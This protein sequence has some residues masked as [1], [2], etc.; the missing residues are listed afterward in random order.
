MVSV[1]C[2]RC[3]FRIIINSEQAIYNLHFRPFATRRPKCGFDYHS[4]TDNAPYAPAAILPL[5]PS[6]YHPSLYLQRMPY[7]PSKDSATESLQ[8]RSNSQPSNQKAQF[9]RT[10]DV[11]TSKHRPI[12]SRGRLDTRKALC[13][14]KRISRTPTRWRSVDDIAYILTPCSSSF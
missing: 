12:L 10:I 7:N 13:D 11:V 5:P 2:L 9:E 14:L 3:P 6:G 1:S 8:V 4:P